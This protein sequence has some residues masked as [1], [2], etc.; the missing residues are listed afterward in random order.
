MSEPFHCEAKLHGFRRTQEGVV[1]SFVLH[2]HEVPQA[3][4]LDPLGTRY[5]LAF[6]G[7]SDDETPVG[8]A[9]QARQ[10]DPPQPKDLTR[11]LAARQRYRESDEMEKARQR[12]VLLCKD[13]RFQD[14]IEANDR[15]VFGADENLAT[16]WLRQ[17]CGV[18]S[19]SEIATNEAA[20]RAFLAI[21]TSYRIDTG[22]M[23]AAR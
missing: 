2:P 14:W 21:E 9:E 5:I 20:Y 10:D 1:V 19:R 11:S 23:A 12:A 6:A 16:A 18:R 13:A 4:A 8:A 7:I 17:A 3:L 15:H 22:Q